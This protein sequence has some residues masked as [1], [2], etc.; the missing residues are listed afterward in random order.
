MGNKYILILFL[1]GQSLH[2]TILFKILHGFPIAYKIKTKFRTRV[3]NSLMT[4]K[5]ELLLPP[6]T[7]GS[8]LTEQVADV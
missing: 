6:P 2:V 7:P 8:I 1:K 3:L 4:R 5:S